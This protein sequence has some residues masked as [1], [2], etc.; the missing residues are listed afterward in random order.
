[1][2]SRLIA[3][4]AGDRKRQL[5]AGG[6]A[7]VSVLVV[8]A[9]LAAAGVFS[10]GSG[11]AKPSETPALGA[12]QEPGETPTAPPTE[13]TLLNGRLVYPDELEEIEK[14][15]PLAVM[16]DNFV[17]ARPQVGLEKADLVFEAV[18][19]GGIT[20][21]LGVFWSQDPGLIEPVRSARAYYISWAAELD[22]IYVH[23]GRAQSS[24][25]LVDVTA[26][27]SRLGVTNFDAFYMG[28]PYFTRDPAR[29]GPH[30][31]IADVGALWELAA[32]R[33]LSGPPEIEGWRFK[34]DEPGRAAGNGAVAAPAV[35]LGFGGRLA[36][37]YAVRWEYDG[38]SN[39]Y[40]RSEGG[41][42]HLDGRSGERIAARN[43][44]VMITSAHSAG[45]GTAHLVYETV[46]S[47]D[48]VVFQDGV[49][50]PGT[51]SRADAASRTRFFDAAGEE[52]AF[53]RGQTWVEVLSPTDPL[54]YG[55]P[56]AP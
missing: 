39:G 33:E 3:W 1:M 55:E 29:A 34:E 56:A 2:R 20:R 9:L 48:A 11:G 40:L 28:A 38:E 31:G 14:R 26:T 21:F 41:A 15:L 22:A 6:G 30:D 4:L 8:V 46:G 42:P 49:A 52:I 10:G 37:D 54:V 17:D 7:L 24:D 19:E 27:L 50:V 23:W 25:P 36:D 32:E 5:I 51:W 44:A 47:G 12:T 16:F 43:V 53:N 13:P 18:A 45:D 35:D